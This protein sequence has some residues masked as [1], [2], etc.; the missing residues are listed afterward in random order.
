[1]AAALTASIGIV[2]SA[3]T[4]PSAAG[5]RPAPTP[6]PGRQQPAFRAGVALVSPNI[7][8]SDGPHYVTDLQQ[9]EFGVFE[10]G[11]KQDVTFF[12]KTNL[13]IAL[14]LLLDTSAARAR[15]ADSSC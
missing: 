10:D 5:Q 2:L 13:P 14:S 4:P 9:D 11:V 12:N 1:M 8:V 6:P 7:A 3:Q 15:S